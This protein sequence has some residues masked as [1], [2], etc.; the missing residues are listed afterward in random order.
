[1]IKGPA[2]DQGTAI[3][4]GFL[5]DRCQL[6]LAQRPGPFSTS[7]RP[8]R[9]AAGRPYWVRSPGQTSPI[10][11][12]GEIAAR[13]PCTLAGPRN[14]RPGVSTGIRPIEHE[15]RCKGPDGYRRP[16]K[17]PNQRFPIHSA[18]LRWHQT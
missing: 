7:C 4:E 2:P 6:C 13:P 18:T 10:T 8:G 9:K 5:R 15:A 16:A 1:L 14:L 12:I 11:P 17:M 3:P